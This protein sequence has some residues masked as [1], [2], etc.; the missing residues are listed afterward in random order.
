MP[1]GVQAAQLLHAAAR[2]SVNKHVEGTNAVALT[3]RHEPELKE[4]EQH[5]I[6]A[7]VEHIAIREPDEPYDN[8]LMAIGICPA[9]CKTARRYLS[10]FPLVK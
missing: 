10:S 3:A 8:Q 2:S 9:P 7:Q 1:F 5:L 4:L 6:R